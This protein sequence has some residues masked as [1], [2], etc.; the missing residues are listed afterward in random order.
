MCTAILDKKS[1]PLEIDGGVYLDRDRLWSRIF[2]PAAAVLEKREAAARQRATDDE[3]RQKERAA[4]QARE[5]ELEVLRQQQAERARATAAKALE[6][7]LRLP[8]VRAD[9]VEWD[10]WV[11]RRYKGRVRHER[12]TGSAENCTLRFSGA[13]VYIQFD[14]GSEIQK[15]AK[16]VRYVAAEKAEEGGGNAGLSTPAP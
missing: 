16:N 1:W 5:Q 2:A 13:R 14:D 15:A 4:A 12:I 11:K 7:K 8:A 3:C 9:R 6:N 10:G